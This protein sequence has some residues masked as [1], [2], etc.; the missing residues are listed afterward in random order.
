MRVT[1]AT[2]SYRR[3]DYEAESMVRELAARNGV[4]LPRQAL[5][6]GATV[7]A[8]PHRRV[9]VCVICNRRTAGEMAAQLEA[10]LRATGCVALGSDE[11]ALAAADRV[12][13][14]L[15]RGVLAP[16]SLA[17]LERAIADDQR[18]GRDRICA[19]YSEAAGWRFGCDEHCGAPDAV[20]ECLDA[21]EALTCVPALPRAPALVWMGGCG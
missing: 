5:A 1:L 13:L 15:S 12:L 11:A 3:R 19:V 7:A 14:L 2:C 4:V 17:L 10:A 6:S 16:P 9:A 18:E 8:P 21:H 20:R